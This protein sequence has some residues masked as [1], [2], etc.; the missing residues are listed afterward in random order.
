MH[1]KRLNGWVLGVLGALAMGGS[2]FSVADTAPPILVPGQMGA[3]QQ[4][5]T[6][7]PQGLGGGPARNQMRDQYRYGHGNADRGRS[8]GGQRGQGMGQGSSYRQPAYSSRSYG[9]PAGQAAWDGYSGRAD[10]R[11]GAYPAESGSYSRGS[12]GNRGAQGGGRG[13]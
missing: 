6:R 8:I 9:Q 4:G 2:A 13:R 7:A 12:G 11:S 1:M 10:G 5:Q 3:Y